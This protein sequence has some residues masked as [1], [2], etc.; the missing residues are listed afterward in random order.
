[1]TPDSYGGAPPAVNE[2]VAYDTFNTVGYSNRMPKGLDRGFAPNFLPNC[3][4]ANIRARESFSGQ[5]AVSAMAFPGVPM[6]NGGF[7]FNA[8]SEDPGEDVGGTFTDYIGPG[9]G[10]GNGMAVGNKWIFSTDIRDAQSKGKGNCGSGQGGLRS[11][12][13]CGNIG[14]GNSGILAQTDVNTPGRP[15]NAVGNVDFG[16]ENFDGLDLEPGTTYKA[17]DLPHLPAETQQHYRQLLDAPYMHILNSGNNPDLDPFVGDARRK[18]YRTNTPC[19]NADNNYH[20]PKNEY[21]LQPKYVHNGKT[22]MVNSRDLPEYPNSII[23]SQTCGN[24]KSANSKLANS[25]SNSA[26]GNSANSNSA[27]STANGKPLLSLKLG[28]TVLNIGGGNVPR[29]NSTNSTGNSY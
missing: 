21:P 25:N 11:T 9:M 13:T 10:G 24:S 1:M 6:S 27:N 8:C 14:A 18:Q 4:P 20:I 12:I 19:T 17:N 2:P 16:G 23:S 22:V 7:R 29:R 5:N 28:N 15:F 26:N 3:N